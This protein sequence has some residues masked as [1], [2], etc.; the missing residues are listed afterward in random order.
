MKSF[1]FSIFFPLHLTSHRNQSEGTVV[2][3][4]FI[5]TSSKSFGISMEKIFSNKA[6]T[7]AING[8]NFKILE[9]CLSRE[10]LLPE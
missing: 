4:N 10:S 9:R 6:I 2:A 8:G 7:N 1:F 3:P 5:K